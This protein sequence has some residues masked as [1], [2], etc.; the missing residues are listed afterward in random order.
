MAAEVCPDA[1]KHI[2]NRWRV[3]GVN[4]HYVQAK[5]LPVLGRQRLLSN[6]AEIHPAHLVLLA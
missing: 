4:S 1:S 3:Q 2:S 5:P 6:Q